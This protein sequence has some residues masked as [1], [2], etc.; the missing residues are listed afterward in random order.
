MSRG[1]KLA[2]AIALGLLAALF[3]MVYLNTE[4]DRVLGTTEIV[5]VYVA[6][7][8]IP[9]NMPIDGAKLATRRIPSTFKQP[10]A[11][12]TAEVSDRAKITGV[13]IV[14]IQEGEQIV[15][16]KLWT[17]KA[18]PLVDDL[19]RRPGM[20]AVTVKMNETFQALDGLVQPRDR[21]DILALLEFIKPDKSKFKEVRPLFYN[22][23]ILAVDRITASSVSQN[24]PQAK[25]EITQSPGEVK[26]VTLALPPVGAQ[27]LVLAQQLPSSRI[28][29]ILRSPASGDYRYET[30]N[31]DRLIQSEHRLWDAEEF[32]VEAQRELMK[33]LAGR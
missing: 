11:I 15:R 30:W 6:A 8:D 5:E 24:L 31:T 20:V 2:I 4:R 12:T 17:G 28:W 14:P 18:P 16:T 27:Q 9:A 10:Q 21:V 23:E 7:G 32:S 29:L 33:G 3:G 1:P 13:A 22:V 26:S 19:K 25:T